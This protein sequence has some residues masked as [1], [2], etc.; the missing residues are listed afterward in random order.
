MVYKVEEVAK[1]LNISKQAVYKKLNRDDIKA[2][3]V[4]VEGVKH[5]SIEGLNKLKG[6]EGKFAEGN[7]YEET[8]STKF[9]DTCSINSTI[10]STDVKNS[11]VGQLEKIIEGKDKEIEFKNKEIERLMEIIQQQNKLLLNSQVIQQKVLSNTELLLLEKREELKQRQEEK[12]KKKRFL[13][14][15]LKCF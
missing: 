2:Y 5:L 9:N 11:L 3:I 8:A 13:F 14:W 12:N 10:Y 7:V 6:V 1:K 4:M 15:T